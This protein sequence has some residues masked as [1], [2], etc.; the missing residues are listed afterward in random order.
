[1]EAADYPKRHFMC[2]RLRGAAWQ[3]VHCG[4]TCSTTVRHDIA[5]E[6]STSCSVHLVKVEADIL[7]IF[8]KQILP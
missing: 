6:Q 1:M 3:V 5:V 8:W 4:C 7:H 2:T